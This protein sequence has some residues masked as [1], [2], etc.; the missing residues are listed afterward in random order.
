MSA[1]EPNDHTQAATSVEDAITSRRSVRAFLPTPVNEHIV[2]ELL[3]LAARAPSGTNTQPWKVIAMAGEAK[4][5]LCE[6][7]MAAREKEPMGASE[8][9]YYP[10][11]WREP[12][13][14]RRR[15]I[16]WDLYGLLGI[17]KADKERMRAQFGRNY[18]FFDAPVGLIF[19]IDRDLELG[20]WLDYGMFLENLMLAARG[21]GLD[22]CP[23]A[24]WMVYPEAVATALELPEEEM[25]VCG[26]SLGYADR[27][28][29]EDAL[30]TDREPADGFASFTGF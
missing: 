11:K 10:T 20:S 13:L 26:M 2:R 30:V 9:K 22:T 16:G 23:Q 27:S 25:V 15:K 4:D 8:Y 28:K 1:T 24:A 14:A 21:L 5:A 19:T 6:A 7:V 3:A 12:Y 29:P 17:E 18:L